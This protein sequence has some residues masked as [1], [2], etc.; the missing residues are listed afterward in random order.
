MIGKL[1]LIFFYS[2]SWCDILHFEPF[3]CGWAWILA[4]GKSNRSCIED[5]AAENYYA[6]LELQN[7][8]ANVFNTGNS[9]SELCVK[10]IFLN[11]GNIDWQWNDITL[12][13]Y[14]RGI[15]ATYEESAFE[16]PSSFIWETSNFLFVMNM[17]DISMDFRFMCPTVRTNYLIPNEMWR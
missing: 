9:L 14:K 8:F 13:L 5:N 7:R 12:D 16:L 1:E 2:L 17:F 6:L 3:P 10:T 4:T 11:N 15:R